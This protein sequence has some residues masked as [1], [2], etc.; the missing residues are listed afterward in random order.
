MKNLLHQNLDRDETAFAARYVPIRKHHQEYGDPDMPA[1]GDEAK[2]KAPR[3][4]ARMSKTRSYGG[5][6]AY[7]R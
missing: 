6:G 1:R 3:K 4:Q 7:L 5:A 2:G